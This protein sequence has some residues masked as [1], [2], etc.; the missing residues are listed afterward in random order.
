VAS[1]YDRVTAHDFGAAVGLWTAS[2]QSAYPPGENINGRF[3]N[4]TSM[5]LQRDE[6][7]STG[8]GRAVVAIDLLEV[9]GG[10]TYHWVGNWYLVQTESGW[11]LDRPGLRPG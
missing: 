4:T 6:V 2:M 5:T 1:F 3:S 10:R 7:V 8:A 11:L 9:R